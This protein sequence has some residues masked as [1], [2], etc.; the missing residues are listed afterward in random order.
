[1]E[2]LDAGGFVAVGVASLNIPK[3]R[4]YM[5]P[6]KYN[7]YSYSC[8]GELFA[9]GSRVQGELATFKQGDNVGFL[10]DLVDRRIQFYLN[11]KL[12]GALP[13]MASHIEYTPFVILGEGPF[14]VSINK[15]PTIAKVSCVHHGL[16]SSS[17]CLRLCAKR[18]CHV[19]VPQLFSASKAAFEK[20]LIKHKS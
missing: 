18:R 11:G 3:N 4:E 7:A 16:Q 1:M 10:C 13:N 19:R 6:E 15:V 9:L 2:V 20:R 14:Q 17:S 8:T 5:P 12:V